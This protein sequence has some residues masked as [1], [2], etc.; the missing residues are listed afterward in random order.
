MATAVELG[1]A[2]ITD[3]SVRP[4]FFS[5]R[6]TK[7]ETVIKEGTEMLLSMSELFTSIIL[8][9]DEILEIYDFIWLKL[10]FIMELNDT[11]FKLY[12]DYLY[13]MLNYYLQ[14]AEDSELYETCINIST[15]INFIGE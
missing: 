5:A 9:Q 12:Y 11:H 8:K 3:A 1:K 10:D 13:E 6:N 4:Y 14:I 15:L 2:F 7:N